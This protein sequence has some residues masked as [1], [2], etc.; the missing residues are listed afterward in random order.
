MA[1]LMGKAKKALQKDTKNNMAKLKGK[2]EKEV[3]KDKPNKK[4]DL[5]NKEAKKK[6]GKA[7]ALTGQGVASLDCS[8]CTS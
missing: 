4:K 5:A 7:D 6:R 8:C 2:A 1:K 3:K